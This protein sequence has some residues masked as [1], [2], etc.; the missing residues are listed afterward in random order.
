MANSSRGLSF[1][2]YFCSFYY[3][4]QNSYLP[5]VDLSEEALRKEND[6][7]ESPEL[8]QLVRTPEVQAILSSPV[9]LNG[10]VRQANAKILETHGFTL[11]P[12]DRPHCYC[13]ITEP[14]S[15]AILLHAGPMD[16]SPSLSGRG[17][18]NHLTP[19][20]RLLDLALSRHIQRV[21][22]E[23]NIKVQTAQDKL[24]SID[25]AQENDPA[26]QYCILTGDFPGL[27]RNGTI[28][29]IKEMSKKEQIE[30]ARTLCLLIQ[31]A[32]IVDP[33]FGNIRL[34]EEDHTF[35]FACQAHGLL[36]SKHSG[37]GRGESIEKCARIGL[38]CLLSEVRKSFGQITAEGGDF[39][40]FVE[41]AY[42]DAMP[43]R[44]SKWKITLSVMSWGLI[45]LI[46]AIISL[47]QVHIIQ[48]K[49][50]QVEQLRRSLVQT[51]S[52]QTTQQRTELKHKIR[53]LCLSI[54][55]MTEA[56]PFAYVAEEWEPVFEAMHA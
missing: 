44:L 33:E 51:V 49:I 48:G 28:K 43:P 30:S 8:E 4:N 31:K 41:Y 50:S 7:I 52:S 55:S 39:R 37:L 9:P 18:H 12:C 1:S 54:L 3:E 6:L 5:P 22:K 36:V 53:D 19:G 46:Y 20:Y 27:D 32:G 29:G 2:D 15:Q 23:E 35:S 42:E 45:P 11:S 47:I 21:A 34:I 40:A 38:T 26:K 10:E 14:K 25:H 17:D 13:S 24:L 16:F 56:V